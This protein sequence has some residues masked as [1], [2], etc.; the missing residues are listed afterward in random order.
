MRG[1]AVDREKLRTLRE[2]FFFKLWQEKLN[3]VLLLFLVIAPA[4]CSWRKFMNSPTENLDWTRCAGSRHGRISC[5]REIEDWSNLSQCMV[6]LSDSAVLVLSCAELF[7]ARPWTCCFLIWTLECVWT[8]PASSVDINVKVTVTE[9]ASNDFRNCVQTKCVLHLALLT[10]LGAC[11]GHLVL[12][13]G[14]FTESFSENSSCRCNSSYRIF[15]WDTTPPP[16]PPTPNPP[17]PLLH[18]SPPL[19][20]TRSWSVFSLCWSRR[21]VVRPAC[22]LCC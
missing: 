18:P 22:T 17:F 6:P 2:E 13:R 1:S 7:D 10:C 4:E 8:V 5:L 11:K 20:C 9:T 14:D 19:I 16:P 15:L 21:G 12:Q 3:K